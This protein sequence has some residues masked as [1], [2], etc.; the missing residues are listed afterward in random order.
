MLLMMLFIAFAAISRAFS[1][2]VIGDI[3]IVRLGMV[4]LIMFGLAFTQNTN[5]HISIGLIVDKFSERTQKLF[6][7][8]AL[9]LNFIITLTI[10]IVFINVGIN[11]MINLKLTTDLLS[12]PYFYF[13]FIIVIGFLLWGLEVLLRMITIFLSLIRKSET[14][15]EGDF[16]V[17]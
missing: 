10:G 13:D 12:V 11:H 16:N 5:S 8:F 2:P 1:F 3:E 9:I 6:D 4:V 17:S 7:F 14:T 15:K